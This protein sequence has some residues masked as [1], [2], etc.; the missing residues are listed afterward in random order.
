MSSKA[1]FREHTG[2]PFLVQAAPGFLESIADENT[3]E[4]LYEQHE[5]VLRTELSRILAKL[6]PKES[7]AITLWLHGMTQSD[8]AK[9]EGV[10]QAAISIRAKRGLE[11]LEAMRERGELGT[12]KF[13]WDGLHKLKDHIDKEIALEHA[14]DSDVSLP[15]VVDLG[16]EVGVGEPVGEAVGEPIFKRQAK[17][18][19]RKPGKRPL[20]RKES[21]VL[22]SICESQIR[23]HIKQVERASGLTN[24][25]VRNALRRLVARN[26][27]CKLGHGEYKPNAMSAL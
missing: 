12:L 7:E 18:L 22:S 13:I 8:I 27:V 23:L 15:L 21:S 10:T 4:S 19:A 16:Q 6:N 20:N 9:A 5:A 2:Q 17:K 26:L 14:G 11:K 1:K 3:P 25:E 24:L